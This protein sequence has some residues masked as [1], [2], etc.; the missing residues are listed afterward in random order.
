MEY[1]QLE[2]L[3][4]DMSLEE[5]VGQMVQIPAGMIAK[6]GLVTGLIDN[7]HLSEEQKNLA[8]SILGLTGAENLRE[9]QEEFMKKQMDK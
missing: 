9:I 8:G 7:L 1:K 6:E 2:A 5:K 3:L 4:Q